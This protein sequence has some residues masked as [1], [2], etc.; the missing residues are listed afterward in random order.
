MNELEE[1]QK[2]FLAAHP[3]EVIDGRIKSRGFTRIKSRGFIYALIDPRVGEVLYVGQTKNLPIIRLYQH[4]A[5]AGAPAGKH[6]ASPKNVWI[7]GL[8]AADLIP[9]VIIL[10]T[11]PLF[12]EL[13]LGQIEHLYIK[14]FKELGAVLVNGSLGGWAN[15]RRLKELGAL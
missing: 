9:R 4:L 5:E 6:F 13:K 12:G 8:A 1:H 15:G 11:Y 3:P 7:R 2:D 10:D 14:A